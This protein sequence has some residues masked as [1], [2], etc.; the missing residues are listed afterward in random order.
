MQI[1]VAVAN[2]QLRRLKTEVEKV[3]V[4]TAFGHGSV[5]SKSRVRASLKGVMTS[6]AFG[7][8]R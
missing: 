2:I 7:L 3:S 5:G 8:L 6:L 4:S 1:L